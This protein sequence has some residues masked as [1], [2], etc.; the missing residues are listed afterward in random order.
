MCFCLDQVVA[1]ESA[2]GDDDTSTLFYPSL[3]DAPRI[4]YLTSFSVAGDVREEKKKKSGWLSNFVLGEEN[5]EDIEGIEKPYGV[6]L[7]NGQI[8]VVDTRGGGYAIFDVAGKDYRFTLGSGSAVMVKPVN[9]EID[10]EGM[11]YVTDTERGRIHIFDSNDKFQRAL[12]KRGQF[13][14]TDVVVD[15]ERLYVVDI[16]AH[17]I[18]VLDKETGVELDSFGSAGVEEGNFFQPTNIALGPDKHLFVSDTGNFR[19]Q[20]FTLDGEFV[21]SFGAGVGTA[22][23]N[24]A[25]PKG[26]A[27]DREGRLYVVDAAFATVQIFNSDGELLLFFGEPA[28]SHRAGLDLPADIDI[29]YDSVPYFQQYADPNFKLEYVLAVANQ[30]GRSRVNIFGFGRHE[31]MS[32]DDE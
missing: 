8:H 7:N 5:P 22:P 15:G 10:D 24:F 18:M 13:R 32:Y 4:Q 1:Q 19:V 9:I 23:G 17:R 16:Q 12:G 14:P 27:V 3:P 31:A 28:S 2:V 11:K 21:Q 20:K 26:V 25:R 6:S 30:F 29:D